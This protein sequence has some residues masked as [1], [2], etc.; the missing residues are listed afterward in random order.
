MGEITL[1]DLVLGARLAEEIEDN[2][3]WR[4]DQPAQVSAPASDLV[5][6]VKDM[7]ARPHMSA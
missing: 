6:A 2:T 7:L 1:K 5:S 3:T 4:E